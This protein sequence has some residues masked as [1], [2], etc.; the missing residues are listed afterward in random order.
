MT[1]QPFQFPA[2]PLSAYIRRHDMYSRIKQDYWIL[3]KENKVEGDL[4]FL[5][6]SLPVPLLCPFHK[7]KNEKIQMVLDFEYHLECP[8]CIKYGREL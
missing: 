8:L 4:V 7:N 2:Y 1:F 3:T 5:D 6:Y